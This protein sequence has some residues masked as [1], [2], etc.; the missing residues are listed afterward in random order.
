MKEVRNIPASVR[1][2]LFA[3]SKERGENFER[4]LVRYGVERFLYRLSRHGQAN[5]FILKGA[6]LFITW[7]EGIHRP[8]GDLDLL[9]YGPPDSDAMKALINEICAIAD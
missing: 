5:R 8:T 7:P 4:T 3:W 9:G 6:M 2:R 1:A